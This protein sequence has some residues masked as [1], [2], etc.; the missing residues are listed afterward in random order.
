MDHYATETLEVK[1]PSKD[2]FMTEIAQ[3][4]YFGQ[5]G[6]KVLVATI[7]TN[8][9]LFWRLPS[10]AKIY[11]QTGSTDSIMSVHDLKRELKEF[12]RKQMNKG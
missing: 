8:E 6:K 12:H 3:R 10:D 5:D 1:V 4:F 2:S 11:N 7:I 9:K